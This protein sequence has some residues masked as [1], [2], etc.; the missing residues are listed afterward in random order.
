MNVEVFWKWEI[1]KEKPKKVIVM[2]WETGLD[3][4]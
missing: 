2:S 3:K 1:L 4:K